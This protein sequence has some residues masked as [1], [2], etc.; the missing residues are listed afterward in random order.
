MK[1]I[2]KHEQV[3]SQAG[4]KS[5]PY[6]KPLVTSMKLDQVVRGIGGSAPDAPL[7]KR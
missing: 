3:E 7:P 1:T 5:R 4:A 2:Q 6:E